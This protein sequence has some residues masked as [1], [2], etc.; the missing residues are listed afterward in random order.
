[1]KTT[2]TTLLL[3]ALLLVGCAEDSSYLTSTDDQI[4]NNSNSPN[5]IQ[6]PYNEGMS[7]ENQFSVT[8]NVTKKDGGELIID[9]SYYGGPHG[10]V[11]VI[12]KFKLYKNTLKK[13]SLTITMTVDNETGA[14]T[15]SPPTI[16]KKAAELYVKFEGL[17]LYNVDPDDIDFIDYTPDNNV[18][19]VEYESL[20]I[21]VSSGTIELKVNPFIVDD[22]RISYN[23]MEIGGSRYSF[24]RR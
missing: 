17:D 19:P 11:K 21:D 10:E 22:S 9:E 14:I 2:L 7:I 23:V 18:Y 8:E 4:N 1:M 24:I 12:A 3:S 5:Y 16:F 15:F 6:L 13:K 20:D